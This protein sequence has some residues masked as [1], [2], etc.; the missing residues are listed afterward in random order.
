MRRVFAGML[1]FGGVLGMAHSA[2]FD[3]EAVL[4]VSLVL[5][6]AALWSD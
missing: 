6:A 5:V 2:H 1:A 3:M 4:A